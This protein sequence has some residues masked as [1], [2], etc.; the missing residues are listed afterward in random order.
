HPEGCG[1]PSP[2]AASLRRL[3]DLSGRPAR[4]QFLGQGLLRLEA[5]GRRPGGAA[6]GEGAARDPGA[7]RTGRLQLVHEDLSF[8]LRPVR[9]GEMPRRPA[10]A[11][12][13]SRLVPGLDL[14]D[15]LL[16]ARDRRSALDHLGVPAEL[17]GARG[18]RDFR[19]RDAARRP[20]PLPPPAAPA[21]A[22]LGLVLRGS[23]SGSPRDRTPPADS[24]PA[25]RAPGRA[26][27]W[28]SGRV[29]RSAGLGA[30]FPPIVNTSL[31]L[32][33]RGYGADHPV[34]AGQVEELLALEVE[35]DETV[36]LQPCFSPV[37]DTALAVVA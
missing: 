31:A 5:R 36:H 3:G 16:V 12:A 35:D 23:G 6:H 22:L 27:A 15:V 24:F 13:A 29:A 28:V 21:R 17:R 30:V 11:D 34:V 7:R 32:R 25:A 19:A 1:V 14:P 10:R 33:C 26:G 18:N 2:P 37:W 8:H 20:G 4:G 9:L